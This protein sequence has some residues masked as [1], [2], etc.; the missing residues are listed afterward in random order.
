MGA[1]MQGDLEAAMPMA[2]RL[3]VYQGV[4]DGVKAGGEKKGFGRFQKKEQKWSSTDSAGKQ[5]KRS[6]SGDPKPAKEARQ[7]QGS[8]G[9]AAEE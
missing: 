5:G 6:R 8:L 4:G 3:N 1:H 9:A 2:Q 7:G